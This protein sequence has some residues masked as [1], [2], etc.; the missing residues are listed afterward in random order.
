MH[1][2][3]TQISKKK[4]RLKI[5]AYQKS[6]AWNLLYTNLVYEIN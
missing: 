5:L 1:C 4:Q 3:D 2:S 6:L